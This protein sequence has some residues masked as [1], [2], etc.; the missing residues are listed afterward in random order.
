MHTN[1]LLLF[2]KYASSFFKPNMKVLEI[3]P[4]GF[5]SGYARAIN[6]PSITWETLD[7]YESAKLT[8]PSSDLYS[9]NI[10]NESYDIVLSGQVI[11]HVKK[12]WLWMPEL[13]RVTRPCGYVITINPL[14]WVY[15]RAPVDCWR[16]YPD[17][18]IALY[19]EAGMSVVDS[20]CE[21]LESPNYRRYRPGV[22]MECQSP[23][24]QWLSR[25]FGRVG[26]PI[27]RSYDTITIGRKSPAVAINPA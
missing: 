24:K 20:R 7:I 6:D 4:D 12:P 13:A 3:G 1:S 19:E 18:M 8:Y 5:P 10:P 21:S 22:S 14:S 17:G 27:E 11:E 15:H 16:I 2:N 9:F 26:F 25:L 23:K